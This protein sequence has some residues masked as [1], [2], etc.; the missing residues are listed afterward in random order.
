MASRASDFVLLNTSYTFLIISLTAM[1]DPRHIDG[2]GGIVDS[3]DDA[4]IADANS[5]Q[6]LRAAQLFAAGRPG[7][8]RKLTNLWLDAL[9]RVRGEGN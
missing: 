6:I 2:F 4:I 5:P 8:I 7:I 3:V 9:D 1:R